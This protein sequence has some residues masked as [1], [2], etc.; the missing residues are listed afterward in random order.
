M[1]FYKPIAEG[2]ISANSFEWYR[3]VFAPTTPA[4]IIDEQVHG[5]FLHACMLACLVV[6]PR[7]RLR[8][9]LLRVWACLP[10]ESGICASRIALKWLRVYLCS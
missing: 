3:K 1:F 6:P 8:I 2:A 4:F 10:M 7:M 5:K 9:H